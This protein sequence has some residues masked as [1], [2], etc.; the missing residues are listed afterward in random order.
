FHPRL[1]SAKSRSEALKTI[2]EGWRDGG[3]FPNQISLRLWRNELYTIYADAFGP[4]TED[5]I[6]FYLERTACALFGLVTYGVHMTMYTQDW[7]VW[8]PTRAKTKQTW[9]LYL[10]NTVAG[11]IPHGMTAFDSLVKECSEEANL[12]EEF[13]KKNARACGA[14]SYFFRSEKG[15]LQPEVQFIYDLPVPVGQEETYIPHP[16][17]GEVESFT[18]ETFDYV[19]EMMHEGRFKPNCALVFI[20]FMIRHGKITAENE[21]NYL[22]IMSRLHGRFGY[23]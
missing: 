23:E 9:A 13:V 3:L 1:D 10:D 15:F 8:V 19:I 14:V 18:L 22:E 5:N 12:E 11:G 2:V 6:A 4:R 21:P 17:D 20:D 7:K 16:L